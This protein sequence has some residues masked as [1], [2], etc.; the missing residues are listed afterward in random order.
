MTHPLTEVREALAQMLGAIDA[1][2]IDS[3]RIMRSQTGEYTH[4]WHEEWEHHAKKALITLDRFIAGQQEP[5]P[6]TDP[7]QFNL[8]YEG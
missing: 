7:N 6:A 1:N 3:L 5:P 8:P 2:A 4:K